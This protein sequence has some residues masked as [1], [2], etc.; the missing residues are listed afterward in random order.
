[1]QFLG[2]GDRRIR[3]GA[4]STLGPLA[5]L[6]LL[7]RFAFRGGVVGDATLGGTLLAMRFPAAKWTPQ[8]APPGV[9]GMAQKENPAMPATPQIAPQMGLAAQHGP[10][11]D[12][13]RSEERRV[14]KEGRDRRVA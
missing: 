10:Q 4:H 2:S 9:P 14:G 3:L 8:V 7:L 1:M 5:V 11:H 6:N 13:I 12:V